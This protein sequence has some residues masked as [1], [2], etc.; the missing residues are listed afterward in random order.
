[1][2]R[3]DFLSKIAV[4][5]TVFCALCFSL[6]LSAAQAERD[7]Q[8]L[9]LKTPWKHSGSCSN[10]SAHKK[11]RHYIPRWLRTLRGRR[12]PT[13]PT[14]PTGATG[15]TGSIAIASSSRY[16][17][18]TANFNPGDNIPFEELFTVADDGIL[19][20]PTDRDFT[21]AQAGRYMVTVALGTFASIPPKLMRTH[22][23]SPTPI[24]AIPASHVAAA[25]PSPIPIVSVSLLVDLEAGDRISL[26]VFGQDTIQLAQ[27]VSGRSA[28]MQIVRISDI[29]PSPG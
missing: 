11:K 5:A 18:S 20:D 2:R 28:T 17:A 15:A 3:I 19:Y 14:G 16:S 8:I 22:G 7:D 6:T 27:D 29:P 12:G 26:E 24:A 9:P 4:H 23:G 1:M 21:F 10:S 25:T 13:G